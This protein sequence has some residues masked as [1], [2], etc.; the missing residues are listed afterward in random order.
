M[1]YSPL[2]EDE[3]LPSR[4]SH[5]PV[6]ES[7]LLTKKRESKKK[8]SDK[9][10]TEKVSKKK[11]KKVKRIK[12][13]DLMLAD[14]EVASE[15]LLINNYDNSEEKSSKDNVAVADHVTNDKHHPK[16]K[17][18]KHKK[19]KKETKETDLKKK[20]SSKKGRLFDH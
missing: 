10:S 14:V 5:Y 1:L 13:P 6:P 2:R 8:S 20:K 7:N 16:N 15:D 9:K 12:N 4:I 11:E 3:V 19:S 18:E 17:T